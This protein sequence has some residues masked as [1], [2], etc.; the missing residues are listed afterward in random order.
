MP[1]A[2][3][4]ITTIEAD[5]SEIEADITELSDAI[6][7]LGGAPVAPACFSV[8][9]GGTNQTGIADSTLTQVT[10]STEVYDVGS[11]FAS[12]AWT[13]PAGKVALAAASFTF[14][15]VSIGNVQ[16]CSIYKNGSEFKSISGPTSSAGAGPAVVIEDIANGTDVYTVYTFLDVDSGTA[17]TTGSPAYCY[18]MGHWISA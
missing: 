8:H 7:G 13:P 9:K 16:L 6:A 18:F 11:H 1:T 15:T 12:S 3:S 5:I 10:F 17:T 4:D 14:G 2:E